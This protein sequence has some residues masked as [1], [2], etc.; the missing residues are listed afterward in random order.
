M[1]GSL[2]SQH[3][4]YISVRHDSYQ[5]VCNTQYYIVFARSVHLTFVALISHC[6]HTKCK[7]TYTGTVFLLTQVCDDVMQVILI[8][9]GRFN[10]VPGLLVSFS[11]AV[12]TYS[13]YVMVFIII[14]F[15][16]LRNVLI[17]SPSVS[18][19]LLRFIGEWENT[20]PGII[21]SFDI[22]GKSVKSL[23]YDS[24]LFIF[25]RVFLALL[26]IWI[27]ELSMTFSLW[28]FSFDY[29][30]RSDVRDAR[31]GALPGR[32][33]A[34]RH[35]RH[36]VPHAPPAY[37]HGRGVQAGEGSAAHHI[38][39]PQLHGTAVRAGTGAQGRAG[40]L[41]SRTPAVYRTRC[42]ALATPALLCTPGSQTRRVPRSSSP[43][44]DSSLFHYLLSS[45]KVWT[46]TLNWL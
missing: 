35:H 46:H 43:W 11:Y 22:F 20:V 34:Q 26:I 15:I 21:V 39:Q 12:L 18:N 6:A 19:R 41:V 28:L 25:R 2:L 1:F 8:E 14:Y 30:E 23:Y 40:L 3:R 27:F 5:D 32:H 10:R 9:S 33:L 7:S 36:R 29:R 13:L 45:I 44:G 17:H 31:A 4:W 24:F 42:T 37:V 38:S 16:K